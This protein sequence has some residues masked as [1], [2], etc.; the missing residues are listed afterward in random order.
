MLPG[1][2]ERS[3]QKSN[4]T[5]LPCRFNI[6]GESALGKSKAAEAENWFNQALDRDPGNYLYYSNRSEA[7]AKLGKKAEALQDMNQA[8]RIR[9]DWT[10][11]WAKLGERAQ[12]AEEYERA[13]VCVPSNAIASLQLCRNPRRAQRR[14]LA[15]QGSQH[16]P[17]G[18]EGAPLEASNGRQDVATASC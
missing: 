14:F 8:V 6:H 11:G 9:K 4:L 16:G 3:R 12:E 10:R 15:D 1:F 17:G 5:T 2:T 18:R 13:A 7:R